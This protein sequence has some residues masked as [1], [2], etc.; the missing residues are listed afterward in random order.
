VPAGGEV[1][2]HSRLDRCQPFLLE[3][4]DLG[5][6]ERLERQLGKRRPAPQRQR[7]P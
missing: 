1:G 5:L 6:R 3:P 7:L 4:R 2:V